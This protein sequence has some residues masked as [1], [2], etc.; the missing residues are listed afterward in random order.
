MAQVDSVG[1][2]WQGEFAFTVRWLNIRAGTQQRSPSDRSLNLWQH[3]LAH[4]EAVRE[5]ESEKAAPR[6]TVNQ[7]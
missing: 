5:R 1:T 3:D 4:F 7:T 6:H 2:N